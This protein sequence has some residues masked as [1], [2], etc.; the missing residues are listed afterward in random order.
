MSRLHA[1]RGALEG[2]VVERRFPLAVAMRLVA[3]AS[4]LTYEPVRYWLFGMP[5]PAALAPHATARESA[6]DGIFTFEVAIAM[7]LLG[8][9]IAYR[10]WLRPASG[11]E[12]LG[13]VDS[14][15]HA[16]VLPT[17]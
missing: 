1:G 14:G 17:E 8:T 15:D 6:V 5:W 2:L 3:N 10:G 16:V 13:E 12:A 4:G 11:E 7:P 9:V